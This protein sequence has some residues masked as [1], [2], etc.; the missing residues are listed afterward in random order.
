[1][2]LMIISLMPW[3]R[4]SLV[5]AILLLLIA[6]TANA[7][8]VVQPCY[9]NLS[10][11]NFTF[12][13]PGY[14]V[15]A[16][17]DPHTFNL[18]VF[19]AQNYDLWWAGNAEPAVYYGS[20]NYGDMV[21]IPIT[22]PGNYNVVVY[23]IPN[24]QYTP[25]IFATNYSYVGLPIGITS[26]PKSPI[27]TGEVEG[28]FEVSAISAYNPNGES[29]YN[30]PNSGA[31]LQL[32]AVVVVEL[33]NGQKQYYW[34]QDVI[35]FITDK[36]EF[37][38]W[39]NV[40]NDSGGSDTLS[41]Y[42]IMGNGKVY[43]SKYY[44]YTAL[45][46]TYTLPMSGYLIMRAY[47]VDGSLRIDFGYELGSGGVVWY[48]HVTITP[49]EPVVNAY[50][51]A[52][53]QLASDETPLDAELVFAGYGNSEWTNFTSLSAELGLYY[54]NG[55]AWLPLPS[56]YDFGIHTAESA[57]TDV[58]VTVPNGL[59]VLSA[60][61]PFTPSFLVYLP[62]YLVSVVSPIPILVNG[63]ETTNYTAWLIGGE[64]LTIGDHV[65]V[66]GNGT[67]FVPS[68]GNETIIVN[69]PMNITIDWETYYLV[70][71]YSTLPIYINGITET[72]NYTGWVRNGETLTIVDYNYVLNNGTM[73]VPSVGNETIVVTNPVSLV[74]NWYPKYL[75]TISSALLIGVNGELTTNY[76]AWLSP[77]S[78][79]ALTTHV[80]VLPN[81]TMFIPGVGNESIIVNAPTT[82][83]INWS[84]R[85]L[86][87]IT[88][89]R[90]IYVNGQLV[91]NYTAWLS[92]G[93]TLTI[94]APTYSAYGGLVLYQPNITSATLTIN[95]PIKL[96]ITYTPNY[97]R[98][99]ILT[100]TAIV[101]IAVALLLMR[102]RRVS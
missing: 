49:Y 7:Q 61:G 50:F 59:F 64:S 19:T 21:A 78:S 77:G 67:M 37:S 34:A 2:I 71:V 56:D 70:R 101:I 97:T 4:F 65:L 73:F 25:Q 28:Y 81:G 75:V 42:A 98:L 47:Q 22:E 99:I 53:A 63:V 29:Q 76:T 80:Y 23:P 45:T 100:I 40:W 52:N 96:T 13:S 48:D 62:Q 94:R 6:L 82:L 72:T 54:W 84:P 11:W 43:S 18:A 36:D 79:I 15:L 3:F 41:S 12:T 95:K 74:I 17:A 51:E 58:N 16:S 14:I 91:S 46:N 88:S 68:I 35:G 102:R 57:F 31:S 33:A 86:V 92:P 24:L 27:I 5:L 87:T 32:N 85:Y 90:P 83:V 44:A 20:I 66:L 26:F 9:C 60:P 93:T 10:Y 89:T 8:T 30:V 38:I 69:K 1:M 39:D 55:S